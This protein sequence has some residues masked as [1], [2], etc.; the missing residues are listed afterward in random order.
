M[1]IILSSTSPFRKLQL[2]RLGI[3]F[4]AFAPLCDEEKLKAEF[5]HLSPEELV[6]KLSLEKAKSLTSRFPDSII[7]GSDQAVEIDNVILGKPKTKQRAIEQ[8]FGLQG[9]SHRLLTGLAVVIEAK[10]HEEVLLNITKLQMRTLSKESLTRYVDRDDPLQCAGA[11]KFEEQGLALF[12][13]IE[14]DDSSAIIGL[15]LLALVRSLTSLG[16]QI[17]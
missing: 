10:G 15:P 6:K 14:T 11:Y 1:Q 8:L 5:I 3:K 2:E 7:I 16:Y 12:D 13:S 17:P 4:E 9:K